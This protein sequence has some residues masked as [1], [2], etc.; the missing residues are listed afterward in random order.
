MVSEDLLWGVGVKPQSRSTMRAATEGDIQ[1]L[2]SII[3][4]MSPLASRY[5]LLIFRIFGLGPRL[6]AFPLRPDSLGSSSSTSVFASK[7]GKSEITRSRIEKAGSLRVEMQ[8]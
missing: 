1:T 6:L 3:H 8:K 4:I 2:Q 5:A 7:E